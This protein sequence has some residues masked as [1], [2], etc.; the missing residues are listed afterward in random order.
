MIRAQ[1][2]VRLTIRHS[3]RL[4]VGHLT[5]PRHQAHSPGNAAVIDATLD[6]F[7]NAIETL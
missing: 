5:V 6:G 4:Q 3:H 7:A 2:F 1:G